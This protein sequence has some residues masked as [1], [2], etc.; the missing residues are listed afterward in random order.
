M[1]ISPHFTLAELTKT[2]VVAYQV[3]NASPPPHL[4][5]AAKALC[6]DLLEPIRNHFGSPVIIHSAY[7]CPG[8]NK[9]IGGSMTSQHMKFEAAD[10]HVKGHD[11]E[12]VFWWIAKESG[13]AF[14]QLILEG[15]TPNNPTWI[16]ISLGEPFRPRNLSRQVLK[17]DGQKYSRV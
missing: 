10:F 6:E 5:V 7:R 17:Y 12:K 9:A 13:L 3:V 4:M 11:L 15:N 14:G 16:H 8:L 2:S 1:R